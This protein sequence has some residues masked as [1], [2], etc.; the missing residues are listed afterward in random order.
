MG[1]SATRLSSSS[2]AR[3]IVLLGR[4]EL[5]QLAVDPAAG[6]DRQRQLVADLGVL[7]VGGVRLLEHGDGLVVDR[8]G[9]GELAVEPQQVGLALQGLAQAQAILGGGRRERSARACW[10]SSAWR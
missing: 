4:L 6:V 7:G 2:R 8:L 3:R 9:L 10:A 1:N 5:A